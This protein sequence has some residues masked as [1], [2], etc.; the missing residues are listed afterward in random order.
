VAGVL[1]VSGARKAEVLMGTVGYVSAKESQQLLTTC[2]Y[3]A[4]LV[5]FVVG[6]SGS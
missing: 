4:V 1:A 2:S 5:V 6:Q 3:A